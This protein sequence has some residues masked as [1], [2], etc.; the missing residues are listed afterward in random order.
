MSD[1]PDRRTI[2]TVPTSSISS[3]SPTSARRDVKSP[4]LRLAVIWIDW[5]AYH[6]A[7]FAGL[8][9]TPALAGR[10]AGIELVGGIGVH[11][12]LQFREPL[13][14]DLPVHTL[15]PHSSW[16][17]ASQLR[18]ARLLW[19]QLSRLDPEAVLV[20]GY[21]TLPALAAALWAK[22]HGRTS[23]LMTESTAQDH[24]RSRWKEAVKSAG[25]RLLF[26]GAVTGG[27]AH[28]R[29]L[30]DLRF[31]SEHVG[32][33]Y[34]V[35]D[36]AA[37]EQSTSDLRRSLPEEDSASRAMPDLP[38][39]PYFLYVGR[40]AP[41]K[42]IDGLLA[43]WLRYREEGGRWP[44]VLVGDGPA[45]ASLRAFAASSPYGPEVHFAGHRG[46]RELAPFYA[47][48]GCFVLPSKREPWGLVVNE[49]MA[50]GLPVLVSNRCGSAE[51]LLDEGGNGYSFD[52][53]SIDQLTHCLKC[54]SSLS[55]DDLERM[56]K[57]ST[58]RITAYSPK[59]FGQ[60]IARLLRGQELQS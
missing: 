55:R 47:F 17:Q 38:S 49:A 31:P 41:E 57:Q 59:N 35:V 50:A 25:L 19:Q 18:L 58:E 48:A 12:G 52:P 32:R 56:G 27:R 40:L 42:N 16:Q 22:V 24:T 30:N 26:E 39:S 34:D 60:E 11:A 9:A 36:N 28:R 54:I 13:P 43:A 14:A 15:L 21:Y 33:F 20:P 5:Y 45:A 53:H 44:L 1:T 3:T 10:V 51:D 46:S 6:V 37:I 8:Q 7:R 23:L 29:Y 2:P 4:S